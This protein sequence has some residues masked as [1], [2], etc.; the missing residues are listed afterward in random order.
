MVRVWKIR[1]RRG[2]F[3]LCRSPDPGSIRCKRC[4]GSDGYRDRGSREPDVRSGV[5]ALGADRL[6]PGLKQ[7]AIPDR[8]SLIWKANSLASMNRA[9][10]GR[11]RVRV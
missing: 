5:E 1:R 9:V 10:M 3:T 7:H 8:P 11:K 4:G 6:P 2:G